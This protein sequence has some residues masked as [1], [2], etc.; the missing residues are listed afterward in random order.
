[1]SHDNIF[2]IFKL[3]FPTFA[4]HDWFQNGRNSIRIR[5]VVDYRDFVFTYNNE[6]DWRFETVDSFI[7]NLRKEK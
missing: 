5:Q 2:E 1:M 7:K 3:L 4:I 6:S